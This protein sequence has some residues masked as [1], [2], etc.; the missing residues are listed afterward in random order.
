MRNNLIL[1]IDLLPKGAWGNNLSRTLPK[2]DWD[3]IRN[4]CYARFNYR[5]AICG[6]NESK[7]DAH[8][9]W[10]FDI[11]NRIQTLVDIIALC[12]ACHGVKHIRNSERIGYGENA[13]RHFMRI[14][15]CDQITFAKHYT[16]AQFL[17]DERNQVLRW[18][19]SANLDRY[20]VKGV[21]TKQRDIPLI[22]SPYEEVDW[23]AYNY[24]NAIT[25]ANNRKKPFG[26]PPKI[27][28]IEVD[29]YQGTITIKAD[30]ARKIQ[31]L[32][33]KDVI[34]TEYSTICGKFITEFKVENLPYRHIMFRLIGDDGQIISQPF[35]LRKIS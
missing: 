19:L 8:E 13:K 7:L 25:N 20:G 3:V 11:R 1:T 32:N 28:S 12:S 24:E 17:F 22:V 5:C 35:D 30:Y 16:D 27:R 2:K 23:N 33:E 15:G 34:K 18:K 14:N 9:V 31:W 29:N 26:M 10:H 21:E 4:K 6:Y